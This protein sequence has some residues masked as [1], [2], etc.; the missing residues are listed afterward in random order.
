MTTEIR[1]FGDNKTIVLYTD[2]QKLYRQLKDSTKCFK[3]VPYEQE[4]YS[5]RRVAVVGA[6]LYFP[7]RY[8]AWVE[9]RIRGNFTHGK[10]HRIKN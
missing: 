6:D 2:E 1:D 10:T 8:R 9:R 5:N 7:K 4:Q 3:V